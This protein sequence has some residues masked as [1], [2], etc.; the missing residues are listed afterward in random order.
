[1]HKITTLARCV[2][3]VLCLVSSISVKADVFLGGWSHHLSTPDLNETHNLV[4]I[5]H[6]GWIGGYFK[7][8]YN[9]DS[10]FAGKMLTVSESKNYEVGV[11]LGVVYGYDKEDLD[12]MNVNGFMPMFI[13][14]A[15]WTTYTV[16]P[17]VML[18]GEAVTLT[19]RIDY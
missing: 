5:E 11:A 14:Y 6:N 9:D 18:L 16:Q 13:P 8:S 19:F 1:M 12:F 15:S 2:A 17:T 3:V 4:A 7:N 10:G